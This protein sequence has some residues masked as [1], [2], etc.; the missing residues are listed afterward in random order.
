MDDYTISMSFA[1]STLSAPFME[2]FWFFLNNFLKAI[3]IKNV[4]LDE[5]WQVNIDY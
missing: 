1:I 2:I 5:Q 4:Y 3:L